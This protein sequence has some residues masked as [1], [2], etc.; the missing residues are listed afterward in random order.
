MPV[1]RPRAGFAVQAWDR[2]EVVIHH[3]GRSV[4]QDLECTLHVLVE[5]KE[6]PPIDRYHLVDT[7]AEN[8]AAIEHRD[9]GL[10]ERQQLTVEQARRIEQ[11]RHF[12]LIGPRDRT[13]ESKA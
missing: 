9:L 4:R 5:A 6:P 13:K 2:L 11:G 10:A 1:V 12:R 7:V 8:E 3:I